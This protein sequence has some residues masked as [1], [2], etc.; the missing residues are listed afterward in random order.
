MTH[1]GIVGAG[2]GAAAAAFTV[3]GAVPDADVT[4]FEKS[5]GLCGRAATRRDGELTYDY[6]ANYLKADDERVVELITETLDDEGLVDIAEPV[7]V[8]D[9]DGDV[10]PGRE[11][12]EHK[13]SYRRGLT[14]IAKR[15]FGRTDATVHRRT[16]IEAVRRVGERWEVEDADGE[17]RGPFDA[18]LLNPP[19][20]QTADLLRDAEWDSPVREA[21][22]DAVGDVP[23]RTVWTAVLHYRFP[24]DAPY[25]GL[26]NTDKAHAVGWLSRE[27][28]KP[29]HVPDGESL[30]VVQ[31]NHDWSVDHYD[32]DAAENVAALAEHAAEIVGDDRLA[33]PAW[34]DH[35]GWRYAQP[36]SG[37]AEGPIDAARR[38]GLF[39]LGDWVAGEGR[40][41]AALANG[42]DVG[43]RVADGI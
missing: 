42:L 9:A 17:T 37:V 14:Q 11:A 38:E 31:A 6:G 12:D 28:C 36:E 40:L 3:D 16:R 10:S 8:F 26:V 1:I 21:L 25:Y 33:D 29:G 2:A 34:T 4:V 13:W 43:E 18:L 35:Q 23:Y 19:A 20:P 30:L 41:H 15:L 27:E 22:V 5:G 7:H 24:L 39:L 32:A